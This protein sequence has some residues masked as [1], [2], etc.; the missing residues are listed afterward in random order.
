M[1]THTKGGKRKQLSSKSLFHYA[2]FYYIIA[3]SF[4]HHYVRV[5]GVWGWGWSVSMCVCVCVCACVCV[6]V[7]AYLSLSLSLSPPCRNDWAV[8]NSSELNVILTE[9]GRM[10]NLKG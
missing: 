3:L 8:T 2:D 9:V 1:Q 10:L 7:C 6:C 5:L 4:L